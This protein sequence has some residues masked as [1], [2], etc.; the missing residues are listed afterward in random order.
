MRGRVGIR[1]AH[2]YVGMAPTTHPTANLLQENQKNNLVCSP[3][4]LCYIFSV[5][6]AEFQLETLEQREFLSASAHH[7]TEAA[8]RVP[9]DRAGSTF[10]KARN[11][12][13]L[14]AKTFRDYVGVG[15][16]V[17]IYK[18]KTVTRV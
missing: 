9:A 15:D 5:A 4:K 13:I 6:N 17:D 2:A 3:A 16:T 18:F 7:S 12:G 11:A 8:V 1:H 14:G 10:A